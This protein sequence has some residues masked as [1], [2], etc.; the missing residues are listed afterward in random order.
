MVFVVL[1]FLIA[2]LSSVAI[3]VTFKSSKKNEEPYNYYFI[4]ILLGLTAQRL[5]YTLS[6]LININIENKLNYSFVAYF[7]VPLFYLFLKNYLKYKI[8][9]KENLTHFAL[10]SVIV[11]INFFF[12]IDGKVKFIEFFIFSTTYIFF[13]LKKITSIKKNTLLKPKKHWLHIMLFQ[14]FLTYIISNFFLLKYSENISN[15]HLKYYNFSAVIW[16]ISLTYLFVSPEIFFGIKTLKKI[17]LTNELS[18]K[19]IWNLTALKKIQ[20]YDYKIHDKI[21]P[22]SVDIINKVERFIE[23]YDFRN[24]IPLDFKSISEGVNINAYHLNYIFKYYCVYSKSDFFNY[25]KV[26]H[27]LKLLEDGYLQNKTITS[28]ISDSHFKSKKTFYNN[29]K[30]FTGKSPQE[31]NNTLKFKM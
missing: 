1:N 20:A 31:M 25:C 19:I 23:S 15:A 16:L 3:I 14:I 24:N 7:Y 18:S 26:L 6:S 8:S 30:K 10:A 28:L 21:A 9:Q 27:I 4:L 17:V 22:N 29:F 5:F 11:L 2:F 13:V 12:E